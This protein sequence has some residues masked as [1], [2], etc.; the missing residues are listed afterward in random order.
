MS[1]VTGLEGLNCKFDAEGGVL[2]GA[3]ASGICILIA[4]QLS[5]PLPPFPSAALPA[6]S[7]T[8]TPEPVDGAIQSID[9]ERWLLPVIE[10]VALS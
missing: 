6:K 10:C 7:K 2:L 4:S 5:P 3:P 8:A 9:H 1:V